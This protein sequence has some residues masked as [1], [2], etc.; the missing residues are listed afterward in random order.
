MKIILAPQGFK[1]S[2]KAHEAAEAMLKG[3]KAFDSSIKCVALPI[4]D[5]G[6]GTVRAL[7]Q[8]T[9]GKLIKAQ[10]QGPLGDKVTAAWGRSGD[11]TTAF[12]EVAAASG[13][14]F[15]HA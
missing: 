14:S 4:A 8:A 3:V 2:M 10:V 5:G 11:G 15:A 13:L 7:V 9:G 12:V 1:G 6:A